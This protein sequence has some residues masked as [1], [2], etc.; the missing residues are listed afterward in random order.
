MWSQQQIYSNSPSRT[1]QTD[2]DAL[3]VPYKTEFI[4][5]FIQAF[6]SGL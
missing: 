3:L 6:I 1:E 2:I 5:M 4:Q